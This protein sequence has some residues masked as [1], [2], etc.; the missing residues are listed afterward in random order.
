MSDSNKCSNTQ[1]HYSCFINY[2]SSI[3]CNITTN[4]SYQ[5]NVRNTYACSSQTNRRS[6]GKKREKKRRWKSR[7]ASLARDCHWYDHVTRPIWRP[8]TIGP[9]ARLYSAA[10][11][12]LLFESLSLGR[13]AVLTRK[14]TTRPTAQNNLWPNYTRL[15]W[16]S[17][18]H[19]HQ[20]CQRR[21]LRDLSLP[22]PRP[23]SYLHTFSTNWYIP[24]L[25][26]CS[27]NQN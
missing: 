10:K 13:D 18:G 11:W 23:S 21:C 24:Y 7:K 16:L 6:N 3:N 22:Y 27:F 12:L 26:G 17:T 1:L 25:F 4:I 2:K 14:L 8:I 5:W 15:F 9:A 19:L 20:W